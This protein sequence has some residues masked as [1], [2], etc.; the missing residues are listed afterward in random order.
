MLILI[1]LDQ[2]IS[3]TVTTNVPV[4]PQWPIIG[5]TNTY[6]ILCTVDIS[7]TT[8]CFNDLLNITWVLNGQPID[9]NH[10]IVSN[11][12]P[13]TITTSGTVTSTL[14]TIGT[15]S[16]NH[17]GLYT[18]TGSLYSGPVANGTNTITLQCKCNLP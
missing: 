12:S 6:T 16:I 8:T 17:G 4:P 2:G 15:I 5:S 7:C 14:T 1:T 3:V 10:F 11:N 9:S 13:Y 18:C